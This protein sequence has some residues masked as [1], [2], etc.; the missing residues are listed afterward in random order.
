[1]NTKDPFTSEVEILFSRSE[2]FQ[3]DFEV[4]VGQL[5]FHGIKHPSFSNEISMENF[6]CSFCLLH[7]NFSQVLIVKWNAS[8]VA[9]NPAV[10]VFI[11][12]FSPFQ[13]FV[14]DF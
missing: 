4:P 2:A 9:S 10:E 12:T 7:L 11:K 6:P 3:S 1:M 14:E 8:L 13:Y 5:C